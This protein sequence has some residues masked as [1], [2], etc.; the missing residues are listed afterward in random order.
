M[1][2]ESKHSKRAKLT[3]SSDSAHDFLHLPSLPARRSASV[4]LEQPTLYRL[5]TPPTHSSAK[6]KASSLVLCS[7]G[8]SAF[9]KRVQSRDREILL[10]WVRGGGEE[11]GEG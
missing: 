5:L 10:R 6:D 1:R 11:S 3:S 2:R 7:P 8:S 9:R 4:E